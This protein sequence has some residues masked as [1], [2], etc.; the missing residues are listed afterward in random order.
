[1]TLYRITETISHGS[2]YFNFQSGEGSPTF[3]LAVLDV[4][5]G[6]PYYHAINAPQL[7]AR[8]LNPDGSF[9]TDKPVEFGWGDYVLTVTD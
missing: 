7:A 6:S 1:M 5:D 3:D 9:I 2:D 8:F 4:L